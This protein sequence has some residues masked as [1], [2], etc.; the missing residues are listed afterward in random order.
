M[1]NKN[2][3]NCGK[4]LTD[5]YCSSCGQ[6]ADTHRITFKNF[7]FH[8]VLHGTFHIEKGIIYTAK[9]ALI[10]PGKAALEYI[11]GKR[12]P[13][14]N[15]FLLILL[16][17]GLML[18]LKH[19]YNE[20][21]IEQGKRIVKDISNLN[22]GSQ[23]MEYIFAHKSKIVIF[24]FV[25]FAALNSFIIFRRKKLNLSEHTIIAAMILLGILLLSTLAII[26]FYFDLFIN[27]SSSIDFAI[28]IIVASLI[29][30]YT[31]YGYFNAFGNDYSK[32][33]FT[34]RIILFYALIFIELLI[35]LYITIGFVTNWEFGKIEITPFN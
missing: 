7:I 4:K 16:T 2:C 17:I 26:L 25:P 34:Y 12:K 8:D 28:Q 11:F 5:K 14:Y 32:L 6:K 24:I 33:G 30:L 22:E 27:I 21:I 18:F 19:Y 10:R 23:K 1:K 35:L 13:Y 9:S 20:I 29:F 15:V 3:L 31:I